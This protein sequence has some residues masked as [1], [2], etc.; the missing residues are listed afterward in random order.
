M[1]LFTSLF[2]TLFVYTSYAQMSNFIDG[3]AQHSL[4]LYANGKVY[5]WGE[6]SYYSIK[7]N[8]NDTHSSTIFKN[9]LSIENSNFAKRDT[10]S[11][12]QLVNF[13]LNEK[14]AQISSRSSSYNLA[15]G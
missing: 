12:P 4:L 2:L 7:D 8:G 14:I 3:G 6:N 9:T 10:I 11:T 5:A 15:L 1:K 13:P